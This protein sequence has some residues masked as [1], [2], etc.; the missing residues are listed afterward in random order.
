MRHRTGTGA[1]VTPLVAALVARQAE[2]GLGD[3]DFSAGIG[4][5]RQMWWA[6]R[7]G[8]RAPGLPTIR[9]IVA[10]YPDMERLAFMPAGAEAEA[11]AV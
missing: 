1:T 10:R 5:S 6:L 3:N 7:V 9:L 2:S 11:E 8:Q 4:I